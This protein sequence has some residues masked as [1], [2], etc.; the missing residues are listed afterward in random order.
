VLV[1][2][3]AEDYPLDHEA[4]IYRGATLPIEKPRI[5]RLALRD[6]PDAPL[7]VEETVVLPPAQAMRPNHAIRARLAALDEAGVAA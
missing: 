6:L 2:L 3:L 4:V 1:D 7:T 5:R